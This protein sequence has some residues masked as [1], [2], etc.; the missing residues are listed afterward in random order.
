MRNSKLPTLLPRNLIVNDNVSPDPILVEPH[1]IESRFGELLLFNYLLDVLLSFCQ[2][3]EATDQILTV[4]CSSLNI[5]R[6]DVFPETSPFEGGLGWLPVVDV[7]E[8]THS[9]LLEIVD[10]GRVVG[11]ELKVLE[12]ML[13]PLLYLVIIALA[14]PQN[15]L[16]FSV[17]SVELVEVV[18]ICYF[19]ELSNVPWSIE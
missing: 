14:Q 1:I 7:N 5:I 9:L 2:R 4:K 18:I 16:Y 19:L 11:R 8:C 12:F 6:I 10:E 17:R 15:I 3:G 13:F